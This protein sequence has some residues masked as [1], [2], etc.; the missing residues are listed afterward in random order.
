LAAARAGS[1]AQLACD[2][3]VASPVLD[4]F[5]E[6]DDQ[7]R[8]E[9]FKLKSGWTG[10]HLLACELQQQL[11]AGGIGIAGVWAFADQSTK[12]NLQDKLF[13]SIMRV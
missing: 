7:R 2:G 6:L 8:I 9:L 10:L 3:R 1:Q 12:I 5:Q 11:E 4:I 13:I